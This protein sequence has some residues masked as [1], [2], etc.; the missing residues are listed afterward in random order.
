MKVCLI[1][2]VPATVDARDGR[3]AFP[4]EGVN[5]DA[6]SAKTNARIADVAFIVDIFKIRY[7]LE[8]EMLEGLALL[9]ART[10]FLEFGFDEDE[11]AM[12]RTTHAIYNV[13]Q[14]VMAENEK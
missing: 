4:A 9:L 13:W 1:S 11:V 6:L 12:M 10:V 5:A 3:V 14:K 2:S 8:S 7:Y